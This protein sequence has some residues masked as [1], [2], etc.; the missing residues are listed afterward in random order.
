MDQR[1]RVG[2]DRGR[3]VGEEAVELGLE[4]RELGDELVGARRALRP[5]VDLGVGGAERRLVAV[6]AG[7]LLLAL[8]PPQPAPTNT[9][10]ARGNAARRGRRYITLFSLPG[11]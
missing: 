6:G 1:L 8:S 7:G 4:R 11:P 3:S 9:T 10:M 2:L 5:G